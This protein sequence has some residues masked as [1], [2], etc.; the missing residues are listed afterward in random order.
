MLDSLERNLKRITVKVFDAAWVSPCII[1]QASSVRLRPFRWK[2]WL[3]LMSWNTWHTKYR[4]LF[5]SANWSSWP[6]HKEECW[7][8][9]SVC[10]DEVHFYF[11]RSPTVTA[12]FI[13]SVTRTLLLIDCHGDRPRTNAA[14]YVYI[15]I[16]FIFCKLNNLSLRTKFS[17]FEI[18]N[19][20]KLMAS[21]SS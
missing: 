20:V 15:L 10:L 14:H 8:H 19:R 4:L 3:R 12:S 2:F 5:I 7:L 17:E 11:L 21:I 13:L 9:T 1:Y 16:V 6:E 18:K